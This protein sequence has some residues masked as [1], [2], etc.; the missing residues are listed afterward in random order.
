LQWSTKR[1]P[2]EA[3]PRGRAPNAIMTSASS[4]PAPDFERLFQSAPGLYLVLTPDFTIVAASDA[5]LAATMTQRDA[6]VGRQ[7]FE[8]F[9]DDPADPK[10]TG[11][12]TVR[13]SLERVLAHRRADAMAVQQY[14]IR[15]PES[16]GGGFEERHW[17][18]VNS[19]VVGDD[20]H[21]QYII[22]RVEDVTEFVQLSRHDRAQHRLA[23]QLRTRAGT[24]EAEIYRR[25]QEIQDAN[26]EL[27]E[28]QAGLE[29]RVRERTVEL[30]QMNEC[31]RREVAERIR[32][33]EALRDSEARYRLLFLGNPH[34]MWVYDRQTLGFLAVNEAAVQLYGYSVDE[35]MAMT[36]ENI[37]PTEDVPALREDVAKERPELNAPHVW[38]HVRKDKSVMSVEIA[39]HTLEFSGRDAVLVLA[40]DVTERKRLETQL[41]QSQK[42]EAIGLLAGGVA[43][44]FNNLLT[45]IMGYTQLIQLGLDPASQTRR[46]SEEILKAA[47]RAASL[48]RQLLAFSRQQVLELRVLDLNAIVADMDKML[49]RMIGEDMDLLTAP[50]ADLGP[51]KADPG[52]IE[53]VLMNL[54]VNARDAMPHGG[55]LTIETANVELDEGYARARVDLKPGP[56]V[57]LAVSDTGCGMSAEVVAR[58]FE[59]FFTTKALGHGTGLG[60]STVH[61]I[62]KQSHGHIEVYSEVGQGTTFK[63]YLPRLEAGAELLARRE[64]GVVEQMGGT[65]CVLLVEDEEIIRRVLAQS[66]ERHGYRVLEAADGSEAIA[67]CERPNQPIDLLVTDVVMPLMSGPELVQRVLSKRSDLRVLFISGYTDRAL[68]HHGLRAP[69]TAFLQKPFTPDTLMQKMRALLDEPLRRAA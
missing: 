68:I 64:R 27:R 3:N 69:G 4:S 45:A 35:F 37:R 30:E 28:L 54:V 66:L 56:Y 39:S 67:L 19:P 10:A 1:S 61:G 52:Q 51:V 7:L 62:V 24:M 47:E 59:P 46:D 20:G 36:I 65:E 18:P 58:I 5:Y 57:M 16:E 49:R 50:A 41:Q 2:R 42:M 25:A 63:I 21:I 40:H 33:D 38:R 32:S 26:R 23:E 55:K 8:V 11:V 22:H 12:A 60:L 15:R 17:S 44:D 14:A 6:I 29:E 53:Q 9:P 48:T 31:L 34:P 43:H 13:S